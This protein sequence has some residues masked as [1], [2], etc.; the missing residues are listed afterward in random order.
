MPQA[1]HTLPHALCAHS[2]HTDP[3]LTAVI[4]AWPSPSEAVR[5][6]MLQLI[7][8]GEVRTDA[9]NAGRSGIMPVQRLQVL[10]SLAYKNQASIMGS[11]T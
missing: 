11:A 10:Y 4:A 8:K 9:S 7:A 5:A 3:D 1:D 2:V 6:H